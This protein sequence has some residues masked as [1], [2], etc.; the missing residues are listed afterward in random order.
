[1]AGSSGSAGSDA[2]GGAAGTSAGSSGMGG[3]AGEASGGSAGSGGSSGAAGSGTAGSAGSGPI[4]TEKFSFFVTSVTAMKE[5]ARA[6]GRGEEGFGGDLRY[7]EATGLAGADKICRTVAVASIG[8]PRLSAICRA[9][10]R[11]LRDSA[12]LKCREPPPLDVPVFDSP[13][14]VRLIEAP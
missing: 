14:D 5:L 7:G 10:D 2:S 8:T 11:S 13:D 9:R 4:P 3:V 1:M 6:F 12:M